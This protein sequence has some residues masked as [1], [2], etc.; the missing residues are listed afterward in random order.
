MAILRIVMLAAAAALLAGCAGPDVR[1]PFRNQYV[2]AD[3]GK[4]IEGVVFLAVWHSVTP[5]FVS[6]GS[7]PF[8]EAR[9]AVSGPDGRVEIPGLAAPIFRFG[10]GVRFYE[11]APGGHAAE[12]VQI[13]PPD[14]RLYG[15]PTV[16]FMRQ[17]KETREE[18]CK[19]LDYLMPSPSVP[20]N[21][22]T[23]PQYL[24]AV[25]RERSDLKCREL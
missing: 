10:L 17:P 19:R 23:I 22:A 14:G 5:N 18:R 21:T 1:G 3:T 12:R 13:T 16:T 25:N 15:N 8:Y 9:E 4:P 2:D 11:F 7:E 20:N 6:G 24:G